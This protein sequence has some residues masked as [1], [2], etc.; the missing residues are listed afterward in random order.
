MIL[1]NKELKYELARL[2]GF[3]SFK[4]WKLLYRG[5]SDGFGALN[6]HAKCDDKPKTFTIVKTTNSNIIGGYTEATW[7]Q[8]SKFK[9]DRNAYIFSLVNE[10]KWSVKLNI[11]NEKKDKAIYC[12]PNSLP[13]F[14]SG[15]TIG[16]TDI[17]FQYLEN[18]FPN[19]VYNFGKS[20]YLEESK[21][22]DSKTG[23]F[24]YL[25]VQEIEIYQIK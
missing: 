13:V 20:F 16:D 5:S 8:S 23:L 7:D 9:S 2:C 14:G 19:V 12:H 3:R 25:Q 11:R 17:Y 21:C 10:E 18:D 1:D 15:S 4:K 24:G 6:F 22:N